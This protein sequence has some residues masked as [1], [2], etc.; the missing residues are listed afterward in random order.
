MKLNNF[1]QTY[2]DYTSTLKNNIAENIKIKENGTKLHLK[3]QQKN[4]E[5]I[6]IKKINQK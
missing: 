4:N 3:P 6:E 5:I 2:K 1:D